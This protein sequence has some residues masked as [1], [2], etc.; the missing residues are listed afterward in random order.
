MRQILAYKD[1]TQKA[2][3]KD[4]EGIRKR[5]FSLEFH[6]LGK[7]FQHDLYFKV[8]HGKLKYRKSS[9]KSLITHYE[10]ILSDN[11]ERTVVYRYDL[12]PTQEEIQLLTSSNELIGEVRKLREIYRKENIFIHLDVLESGECFIEV[13][14]KDLDKQFSEEELK[15]SCYTTFLQLGFDPEV[16][17]NTGYLE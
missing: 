9:A 4:V 15:L 12:N 14:V 2:F 7:E 11:G 8:V 17:I 3:L 13:E 16:L 10:R 5:I 6:F 1:F